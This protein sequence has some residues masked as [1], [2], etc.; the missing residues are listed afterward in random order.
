[1]TGRQRPAKRKPRAVLVRGIEDARAWCDA[2]RSAGAAVE[3]WSIRDG[4]SAMGPLWFGEMI[5]IVKAEYPDVEISAVLDCGD[6]PG[7]ALAALRQ[8][9]DAIAYGGSAATRRKIAAI[10][11]QSGAVLAGRPTRILDRRDADSAAEELGELLA[12]RHRR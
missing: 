8:G 1:M 10:A 3:L 9:I 6:A 2:A 5:A 12:A 11:E 4:A 7:H